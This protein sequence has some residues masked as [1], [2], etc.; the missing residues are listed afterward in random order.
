MLM[1]G[2]GGLP[3][4]R[5][6]AVS[7]DATQNIYVLTVSW[8]SAEG[9]NLFEMKMNVGVDAPYFIEVT[10]ESK[11]YYRAGGRLRKLDNGSFQ[12]EG[13]DLGARWTGGDASSC[14]VPK[15]DLALD[16]GWSVGG[17][18]GALFGVKITN[19]ESGELGGAANGSQPF[20]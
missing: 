1:L 3:R 13:F 4:N 18:G 6:T 19:V 15:L 10:D 8:M 9:K 12:I 7:R 14:T 11:N 16:I 2:C 17:I 20:R 5:A